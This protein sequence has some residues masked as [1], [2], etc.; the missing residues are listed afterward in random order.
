MS[1]TTLDAPLRSPTARER[2]PPRA[3]PYFRSV[4]QGLSLGYRRGLKG[5]TW[6]ARI[7]QP[8]KDGYIEVKLA[9]A[10]DAGAVADN[11]TVLSF[12]KAVDAAREAFAQSSARL[13]SGTLPVAAKATLDDV[14]T[15]YRKAYSAGETL[16]GNGPGRDL[17]NVDSILKCHLRPRLGSVRLDRLHDQQ[18]RTFKEDLV[19]AP[20]LSRSGKPVAAE[21]PDGEWEESEALRK[22]KARANRIVTVLRAALNHALNKKWFAT[23]AAWCQAL[24][25]FPKVDAAS[26]RF[27]ELD[28]CNALKA[29]V[30]DDFRGLVRG[31]LLTGCRYGSLRFLLCRDV[32]LKAQ[33]ALVRVSKS[34]ATQL[35]HLNEAGC[36]FLRDLM[37]GR[38][39]SDYLFVKSS[40][41]PWKP[42]DQQRRMERGCAAANI[43]PA[44]TF[45][46]LRDTFASHLVKAGVPLLTV[47]KL[48]GHHDL[49][50]TEKYYA[51]LAPNTLK[52]AIDDHLPPF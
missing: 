3:E 19:K 28:E 29:A 49:R 16:R 38:R 39:K 37:A 45:H 35:I 4:Q 5:G 44:I 14:F 12:D 8:E 26:V 23:D 50:T 52:T 22:R 21:D 31:A 15:L 25:P 1:R 40:G 18:L 34:G 43:D 17:V 36:A 41:E 27:L 32:D 42:S 24:I 30:D 2:L 46:E 10:D 6:L 9:A 11:A 48:L 47:S 7:R 20:R 33:T 13:V 51:H